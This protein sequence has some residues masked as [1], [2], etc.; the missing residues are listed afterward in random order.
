MTHDSLHS[1]SA[2]P[3]GPPAGSGPPLDPT[4]LMEADLLARARS[5]DQG[6]MG[7]VYHR[8]RDGIYRLAKGVLRDDEDAA[9]VTQETFARFLRDL[10]DIRG[11]SAGPWLFRVA[12]NLA[13]DRLRARTL[14]GMLPLPSRAPDE[15][16]PGTRGEPADERADPAA[17]YTR[18]EVE[19][20]LA[21]ALARLPTDY[22]VVLHLR[23]AEDLSYREIAEVLGTSVPA[24]E[25]LLFRSRRRL[26]EE[27]ESMMA[28]L[29]RGAHCRRVEPWLSMHLDRE[30]DAAR[31]R[32]VEA[33]LVA[34]D[35]C[36]GRA[37]TMRRARHAHRALALAPIPSAIAADLDA[38]VAGW[39][40]TAAATGPAAAGAAGLGL[41]AASSGVS[42]VAS[43]VAGVVAGSAPLAV[44]II[45]ALAL[46]VGAAAATVPEIRDALVQPFAGPGPAA[47]REVPSSSTAPA[48]ATPRVLV[49]TAGPSAT[50]AR[51]AGSPTVTPTA[52][53]VPVRTADPAT[54]PP[55]SAPPVDASGAPPAAP[56][57]APATTTTA[58]PAPVATAQ[59]AA[60]AAP[61]AGASPA[62]APTAAPTTAPTAAPIASATPA[63][64]T[65]PGP[66]AAPPAPAASPAPAPTPAATAPPGGGP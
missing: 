25:S 18:A 65:A 13:T 35:T 6:A 19:R 52:T 50:P 5:G 15:E 11:A 43:G 51:D 54:A 20:E 46:G 36:Q 55:R 66:T 37:A 10:R 17:A 63:P 49:P 28:T 14:R 60:S 62:A 57:A 7:D 39:V 9:D 59:P 27:Y 34:C 61:S 42:A 26:R 12:R 40:A 21:M 47:P 2:A 8:Y 33:H 3:G 1:P 22:R 30:L 45:A 31:A 64:A 29:V 16:A 38:K 44:K 53:A 56:S 32:Q 41:G 4:R 23:E 58:A 48:E 24:V